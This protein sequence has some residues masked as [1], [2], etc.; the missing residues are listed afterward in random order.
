MKRI[1]LPLTVVLCLVLGLAMISCQSESK[2]DAKTEARA[3]LEK[4]D[5]NANQTVPT[6][7][8]A[9]EELP[10]GPTTLVEFEGTK[11]D[12][13]IIE[14]GE[15]VGHVFKFKNVGNEP[16]VLNN[17]KP[18]CGCTTP[19][20]TKEPVAPGETGEIH[21]EF[22]SKGKSGKQTKTI[23]VTTNTDPAR[24]ILTITGEIVKP[25]DAS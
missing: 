24:T 22:D 2:D 5:A 18:S 8:A 1:S 25:D 3:S 20:W 19:K 6:P 15:K 16:L 13:G 10:A 14:Q 21:V 9:K 17:V 4:S 11:H 7:T 12:Y 23:T